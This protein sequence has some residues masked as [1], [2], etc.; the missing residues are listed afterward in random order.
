MFPF[1]LY[2]ND[3]HWIPPFWFEYN[4]F[5]KKKNPFWSHAECKL[6]IVK[7]KN[8]I[9]GRIAA[10]IDY[11]FCGIIGK[12]IGFFGFFECIDD[13]ECAQALFQSVENWLMSKKINII[14]GPINGR[15][16]VG[17]GFLYYGFDS[18]PSLLSNYSPEYYISFVEKLG[19]KKLKD[20]IIYYVDLTKPL[21]KKL[22][23]K[24]KIC[25]EKN[26]KIRVF[27][28]LRTKKELKWWVDLFLE[29][30]S[31]HWGYVPVSKEE[32][33]KRFGIKQIRWI[34]DPRLFLIAE[35]KGLPVGFLWSTPDY[36]QIFKNLKGK[37]GPI[38]ILSI[39]LTKKHINKGK[40][41]L[42]GIKKD[43]R[44]YGI[45]SYLNYEILNNMKNKGYI[46]AEIGWVDEE[47]T[48]SKMLIEITG[49]KIYK[50]YRIFEKSIQFI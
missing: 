9:A 29:T 33:K 6:F 32:V 20:Q 37:L 38:Q 39:L 45:G 2:K 35:I 11:K 31:E 14:Y 43:Y 44:N 25:K 22:E 7:K 15:V 40:L 26:V 24:A 48:A 5:F 28:R 50:K 21:P 10:I 42:I 41:H 16:D 34:V 47:N 1:E 12:K 46:G 17:C 49:A 3:Q 30:F 8:E 13:F 4:D 19:M 23:E 27:N 18:P 36:N